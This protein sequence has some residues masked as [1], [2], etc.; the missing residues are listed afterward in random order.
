M[1]GGIIA[2]KHEIYIPALMVHI[3]SLWMD[4]GHCWSKGFVELRSDSI[5]AVKQ[6]IKDEGLWG[7]WCRND[8]IGYFFQFREAL[9]LMALRAI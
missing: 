7:V 6:L 9:F 3:V 2:T 4:Q 1:S 5:N 8:F